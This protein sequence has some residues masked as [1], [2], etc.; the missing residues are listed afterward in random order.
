M[1]PLILTIAL[2]MLSLL[3]QRSLSG[4]EFFTGDEQQFE[5]TATLFQSLPQPETPLLP[6]VVP[7]PNPSRKLNP[8]YAMVVSYSGEFFP[9]GYE[10]NPQVSLPTVRGTLTKHVADALGRSSL[11]LATAGRTDAGVSAKAGLFSF[12]SP[13]LPSEFTVDVNK[14]LSVYGMKVQSIE[15]VSSSFHATFS[16]KAREYLYV[17]PLSNQIDEVYAANLCATMNALLQPAI[18]RDVDYYALS[19]GPIQTENTLCHLDKARFWYYDKS[20]QSDSDD[21]PVP[22]FSL[23]WKALQSSHTANNDYDHCLI[24]RVRANRFLRRMVRKMVTSLLQQA[25]L[26]LLSKNSSQGW[27]NSW[28]GRLATRDRSGMEGAPAQGLCLWCVHVL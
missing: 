9:G 8:T 18:G 24:F 11:T 2:V 7:H 12:V 6:P 15:Q 16:T 19:K 21:D 22:T 10:I 14:R 20:G 25:E 23:C 28:I 1:A 5:V 26:V 3:N 4:H 27:Q 13:S 17:L